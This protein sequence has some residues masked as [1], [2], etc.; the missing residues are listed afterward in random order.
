MRNEDIQTALHDALEHSTPDVLDHVLSACDN[1]KGEIIPMDVVTKKS[2]K[3]WTVIATA[4][5]AALVLVVGCITGYG[6]YTAR[7]VE[8]VVEFDVNPSLEMELNRRDE[9]VGVRALN[10][11][12]RAILDGMDLSGTDWNVA[13][14]ALIGSLVKNG[15][16]DELSNSILITVENSD[17]QKQKD[18]NRR[19]TEEI[20]R[21]LSSSS[22]DGA[23]LSQSLNPNEQL[24]QLAD[25]YQISC[26]KAALIQ[27]IIEQRPALTFEELAGRTIN[28]LN[29]LK[30][31]TSGETAAGSS[32]SSLTST[33][34]ASD[35]AYIGSEQA[36]SAALKH[37][38]VSSPSAQKVEM[39]WEEGRMV[40]EVEFISGQTEYEYDIDAI[41]GD[42]LKHKSEAA[43]PEDIRNPSNNTT[44][45]A[46]N[47]TT[48]A[49]SNAA[50]QR[51]SAASS[52]SSAASSRISQ[53]QAEQA[54]LQHAGLSESQV[55]YIRAEWDWDD[56]KYDVEFFTS[57]HEYDYEIDA[58][59]G[60]VREW[61]KEA[62]RKTTAAAAA[63]SLTAEQAR[64]TALKHAGVS[65]SQVREMEVEFDRE[66]QVYEVEFKAS[67]REYD[68]RISTAGEILG[69][70]FDW[71]D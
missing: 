40:Y 27:E 34:T 43:D 8:S 36:L 24:Q 25:T 57:T 19:L 30:G 69:Y 23:I 44:A 4:A 61:E 64:D 47:K 16:I 56:N 7:H 55:D 70:S 31:K 60:A 10:D 58:R 45:T 18:L 63:S 42:V 53:E 33:G 29:L 41:S 35:K 13:V 6:F 67:G 14:N 22:V 50:P 52:A 28:E 59:T 11:D 51:T 48:T 1:T 15:Y 71:D 2:R 66:D 5:A 68:Y 49:T 65:S 21:I 54:A 38:G 32:D 9:V 26:G 20:S 17:P 62:V 37:A 12:A 46:G 39:D 3:K